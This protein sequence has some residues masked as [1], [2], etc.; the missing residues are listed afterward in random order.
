MRSN[1]EVAICDLK[2]QAPNPPTCSLTPAG[3]QNRSRPEP[4]RHRHT[5]REALNALLTV[6]TEGS[7]N[8]QKLPIAMED[9][10]D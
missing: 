1:L 8:E 7:P 9:T 2:S 10:T 3:A 5:R 4:L 6:P